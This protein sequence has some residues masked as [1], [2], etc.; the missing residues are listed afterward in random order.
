MHVVLQTAEA[1]RMIHEEG[2][3]SVCARHQEMAARVRREASA[4]GLEE[5]CPSL[6]RRSTTVTALALPAGMPPDQVRDGLKRRGILTAA[7]LEQYQ[8]AAFRIGHMGD[9]RIG[10][11]ATDDGR[12]C[13]GAGRAMTLY[14]RILTGVVVGAA[15][16]ALAPVRDRRSRRVVAGLEPVGTIF[17]RLIT[18]VVVPLVVAGLFTGVASLGDVRRLGRI[19]GRTLL[20]FL[21]TTIIAAVI[22]VTVAIVAG[23]GSGLAPAVRMPREPVRTASQPRPRRGPCRRSWQTVV[24]MVPANPIAAAAQGD[25]LA[26]IFIVVLF[27]AAATTLSEER[28]R[29]LVAFF[30]PRTICRLVVIQWLM[31]LAPFAVAILIA[32]TV[33]RSG[34]DLIQNLLAYALIVVTALVVHVVFVLVPACCASSPGSRRVFLAAVGDAL[35]LA[36][37][38]A[39]SSVTLPVS[40]AAAQTRLGVSTEVAS[41]VLPTGT[42]LNKNG[43]AVYKAV[44]AV[45]LARLYGVHLDAGT[46]MTIISQRSWPRRP[47]R[48]CRA[49]RS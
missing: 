34:A 12:R 40:L 31:I 33:L 9:I 27:A 13:G 14:A 22:G 6:T 2:F 11:R 28:R 15:I 19:G 23:I 41:F 36:F 32:V 48:A 26:V 42:T 37:S 49:V 7:A 43:A 47:A 5:Q 21:V 30:G 16:G 18:M 1:L 4:L 38:T 24:G 3:E 35:L 25:L 44:T 46:I 10:R 29:P 8:P 45:F 20:Y 17:I 39:A